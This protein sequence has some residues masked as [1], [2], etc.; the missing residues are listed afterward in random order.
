M[1]PTPCTTNGV[2][3]LL[4]GD[5]VTVIVRIDDKGIHIMTAELWWEQAHVATLKGGPFSTVPLGA[6]AVRV[7]ELINAASTKRLS[8][9]RWCP[10]CHARN[11]PERMTEAVCH[12]CAEKMLG[13]IF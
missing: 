4:G 6:A 1:V 13:T 2:G 3:E 8:Q 9:Y 10:L 7:A 11:E 12:S 5:P